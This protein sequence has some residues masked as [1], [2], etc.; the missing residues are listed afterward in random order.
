LTGLFNRRF[1]Q[2]SLVRELERAR[3]K[4]HPLSLLFI[5]LDHFKRFN[6]TFGH[7]TGDFVLRS[8]AE[9]LRSSFRSDDIVCR[10]GGEEFA[11]ILPESSAQDSVIRADSLRNKVKELTLEYHGQRLGSVTLSIGIAAFPDHGANDEELLKTAD[12]CLYESKSS[13]R[14]RVTMAVTPAKTS[15]A[16]SLA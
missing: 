4:K 9:V 14:D 10:Y 7:D 13:G 12:R 2:E 16:S 15:A 3:R 8:L 11:F 6:D 1:L 5:D